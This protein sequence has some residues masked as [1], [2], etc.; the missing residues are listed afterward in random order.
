MLDTCGSEFVLL[1]TVE[2][3]A[4]G[5]ARQMLHRPDAWRANCPEAGIFVQSC[6]SSR[7]KTISWETNRLLWFSYLETDVLPDSRESLGVL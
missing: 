2:F 5:E 1:R 4:A 6:D 3:I 7:G